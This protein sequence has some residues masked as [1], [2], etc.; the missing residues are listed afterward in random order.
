VSAVWAASHPPAIGVPM[1]SA[2]GRSVGACRSG[3]AGHEASDECSL[4]RRAAC[5]CVSAAPYCASFLQH[6]P[7]CLGV[8]LHGLM[9]P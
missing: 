3:V 2:G 9:R 6:S 4:S 1:V 7:Y 5:T 8:N